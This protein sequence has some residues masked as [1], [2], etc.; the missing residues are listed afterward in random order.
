MIEAIRLDMEDHKTQLLGLFI[1]FEGLIFII[2]FLLWLPLIA[3]FTNDIWRT[4]SMI[5]MIPLGVIQSIK[6]IKTFIKAKI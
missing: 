4:R 5:L 3:K 2:Y 1:V 6:S